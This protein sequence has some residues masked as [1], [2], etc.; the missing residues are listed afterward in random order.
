L[1]S[2]DIV[3]TEDVFISMLEEAVT[4]QLEIEAEGMTS[5]LASTGAAA[6]TGT[7]A[8]ASTGTS[9]TASDEAMASTEVTASTSS[10]SSVSGRASAE[11]DELPKGWSMQVECQ[12]L[13]MCSMYICRYFTDTIT[14]Y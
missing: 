5:P 14:R 12:S 10:Q 9:A 2:P 11:D 4:R 8:A 6:S 1:A 7:S 3:E 13:H